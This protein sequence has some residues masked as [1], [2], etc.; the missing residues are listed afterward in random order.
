MNGGSG[1]GTLLR[2]AFDSTGGF[3]EGTLSVGD[4]GGAVF[5]QDPNDSV[6]KLAGI[7][8]GVDGPF[9]LSSDGSN[10]FNAAIFDR[11]GLYQYEGNWVA[12]SGAAYAYATR[13]GSNDSWINTITGSP[14]WKGAAGNGNWS[15]GSNWSSAPA[16]GNNLVFSGTSQT[17]TSN[18]SLTSVGAITFDATAGSFSL[19]GTALT[20]AGGVTNFST[21]TE[22]IGLNLT[23]NAPQQFVAALGNLTFNGTVANGG[24]LLT[25][26]GSSNM[27]FAGSISGTAGLTKE[28]TGTT[29]LSANNTYGGNTTVNNGTLIAGHVHALGNAGLI[30]QNT[31]TAKLQSGLAAPV[32]LTSLTMQGGTSPSGT[33]DI[34]DNNLIVHNGNLATLTA[35]IKSGLNASGTI[36]AGPGITSSTAAA[37]SG[38]I[39][40]VGIIP[41]N[42]GSGGALYSTWPVGADS[43]GAVAVTN[44]DDLIKFTYFG[45]ADL[46]GVVDSTTDYSLWLTGSTSGGSLG[47]WLYGD[48]NYDGVVDSTLDYSLWLTGY[49]SQTGPLI[50]GGVEPVPEPSTLVLIAMGLCG[51]AATLR[52]RGSPPRSR[53]ASSRANS[54]LPDCNLQE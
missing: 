13:I 25:L 36:W 14:I 38:G 16:N 5:I 22:T 6:W 4:S 35:Q 7:N 15:S 9:S 32:Q 19:S 1:L 2:F 47:G 42:N 53:I 52:R 21:N 43:G 26:N 50:A 51:L 40:A 37:D 33:F 39:T 45:D 29:T 11:S 18:N 41:N 30:I 49:T 27:S 24:N 12:E 28:G 31:A 34:T 8:Y 20:I 54:R 17:T 46:N 44:T 48:F 3:N 23:L 10:S